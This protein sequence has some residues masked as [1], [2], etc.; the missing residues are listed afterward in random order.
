MAHQD[1]PYARPTLRK[2][3]AAAVVAATV[4]ASVFA[5]QYSVDPMDAN[6]DSNYEVVTEYLLP[7]GAISSAANMY[8]TASFSVIPGIQVL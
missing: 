8:A 7:D 5:V 1:S 4:G 2:K 3:V 6:S